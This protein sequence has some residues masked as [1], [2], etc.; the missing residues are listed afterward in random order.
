MFIHKSVENH[1]PDQIRDP[2][3]LI[4][5]GNE[6]E[7]SQDLWAAAYHFLRAS[8]ILRAQSKQ[9]LAD[10]SS[11]VGMHSTRTIAAE[12]QKNRKVAALYQ[13]QSVE[14]L[15]RARN[16]LIS[17]LTIERD[18]DLI[19]ASEMPTRVEAVSLL[20][21][22]CDD[23]TALNM[24]T[25]QIFEPFMESL[26]A[27][28]FLQ[29]RALF[30]KLFISWN[31]LNKEEEVPN[32]SGE[33]GVKKSDEEQKE[34]KLLSLEERLAMLETSL[35]PNPTKPK[36]D[37]ERMHDLQKSL[38]GLGVSV[39]YH[40]DNLKNLFYQD[41]DVSEEVQV[42]E[43]MNM[44]KD[45]VKLEGGNGDTNDVM[46]LLKKSNLRIDLDPEYDDDYKSVDSP[47]TTTT[48]SGYEDKD[49]AEMQFWKNLE[50]DREEEEPKSK[51]EGMKRYL[52]N[53]QQLLLQASVCLEELEER[54]YK[55]DDDH[56]AASKASVHVPEE[57]MVG[58]NL[59]NYSEDNTDG[60]DDKKLH[61]HTDSVDNEGNRK[62]ELTPSVEEEGDAPPSEKEEGGGDVDNHGSYE[63]DAVSTN[64]LV[65]KQMD[66]QEKEIATITDI[67][68]PVDENQE[69]DKEGENIAKNDTAAIG[70]AGLEE[71]REVLDK[72]LSMWTPKIS[73]G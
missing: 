40:S 64:V 26:D 53:A 68:P 12:K 38:S 15:H 35:P 59:E 70:K 46:E 51:L 17:A 57:G 67:I 27:A 30:Q 25:D 4:E 16:A 33:N 43:I 24:K 66:N 58:K 71:A 61:D 63:T 42:D 31:E 47:S 48:R 5:K 41:N 73:V 21:G 60:W 72:L 13:D 8:T 6:L 39:P 9:I 2:F 65:Q 28:Q 14:Y 10:E 23:N 7:S 20:L 54:G 55:F 18:Q 32:D 19:V 44:V 36:S 62:S 22:E 45:E 49:Y 37:A 29:R 52:S 56:V 3:T 1:D 50:I 69:K 34:F 11:D